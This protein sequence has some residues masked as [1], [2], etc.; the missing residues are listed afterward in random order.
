M[1]FKS[2]SRWT[3]IPCSQIRKVNNIKFWKTSHI[4]IQIKHNYIFVLASWFID[5]HKVDLKSVCVKKKKKKKSACVWMP[6]RFSHVWLF[7]TLWTITGQALL[8][9]GF[10]GWGCWSGLP[11]PLTGN[12]S[13]PGI[14]PMSLESM[15][16]AGRF[17]TTNTTCEAQ[18]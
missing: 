8:S 15:A 2:L 16:L 18:S 5:M 13:H 7:S 10:S 14:E 9:M 11:C 1:H 6:S 12:L 17:L 3:V 4:E